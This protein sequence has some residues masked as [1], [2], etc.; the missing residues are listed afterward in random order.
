[1]PP[2]TQKFEKT[3]VIFEK[4]VAGFRI[5]PRDRRL[6]S[7]IIII[8][9]DHR[10]VRDTESSRAVE[11]FQTQVCDKKWLPLFSQNFVFRAAS[12]VFKEGG[13]GIFSK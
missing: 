9:R 3:S 6:Q 11:F 10:C 5:R 8:F 1:M 13:T 2:E 7:P 12:Y 4:N